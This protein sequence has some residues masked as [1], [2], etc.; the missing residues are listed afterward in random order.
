VQK[1]KKILVFIDWFEP[2]YKAGGPIRSVSNLVKSL[3][4]YYDIFVF[5]SDRDLGDSESMKNIV[6]DKWVQ[7]DTNISGFY[8]TPKKQNW[9]TISQEIKRVQPDFIYCNSMFSKYYSIYPLLMK[10][11]GVV[12]GKFILSPKGMLRPSALKFKAYKKKFFLAVF[13]LLNLHKLVQFHATDLAEAKNIESYFGVTT[14][15]SILDSP[16]PLP[17]QITFLDKIPGTLKLLF[18]GRIHPIKQLH[19][20]LDGIKYH[21]KAITLTIVGTVEDENY[22]NTCKGIID[23]FDSSS[24]V[25]IIG[26]LTHDK[27]LSVISE[28]HILTLPTMGENFS[29]AIYEALSSGRPVLISDQTP[30]RNLSDYKAGWDI[31]SD[32]MYKMPIILQQAIDW[33]QND[34]DEWV[35]GSRKYVES[36]L[37]RSDLISEYKKLFN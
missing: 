32:E 19:L 24:T 2:A 31:A 3:N 11:F 15:S 18:V 36:Y 27:M 20:V 33:H 23:S 16:A 17:D 34:F 25:R 12:E 6:V 28:H 8:T 1:R 13:R 26:E 4:S 37:K 14:I 10:R 5:T 21:Q 22:W 29:H 7:L 30:W 35:T 9:R